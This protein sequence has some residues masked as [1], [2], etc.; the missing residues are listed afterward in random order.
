M[1]EYLDRE[2]EGLND[3]KSPTRTA[4]VQIVLEGNPRSR[5][6][7]LIVDLDAVAV[8]SQQ[9]LIG[10][11]PFIDSAYMQAVEKACK[12]DHRVQDEIAKMGLTTESTVVVESWAY[13]TDGTNDMSERTTM[14]CGVF[15]L[16][17][18][19]D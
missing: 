5:F 11:H 10:K 2:Q 15:V 14:V 8:V 9:H 16:I 7:E 12:A 13:A 6:I 1:I 17:V 19:I 3:L 4:R 18:S